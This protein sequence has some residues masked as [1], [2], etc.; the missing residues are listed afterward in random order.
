MG[1]TFTLLTADKC[2]FCTKVKPIYEELKKEFP[3]VVFYN[4]H[5]PK[6][7]KG[8]TYP[9]VTI[10][11]ELG[12]KFLKGLRSKAEYMHSINCVMLGNCEE[13]KKPL[14]SVIELKAM[15][16]DRMALIEKSQA[17]IVELN[18]EIAKRNI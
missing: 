7:E 2:G 8:E 16:Y 10:E 1:L 4:I 17:E 15:V 14:P 6:F 9:S 12:K 3:D 18:R 13:D 5:R 11:G